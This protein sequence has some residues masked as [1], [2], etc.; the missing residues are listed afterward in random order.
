[1]RRCVLMWPFTVNAIVLLPDHLHAMW[2]LPP[3]DTAY[4]A[5]WGWIKKEFSREWLT[6]G[7]RELPVSHAS[8]QEGRRGVWQPRY[9]EHT[10][11]DEDDFEHH[12]DYIHFNPVKHGYVTHPAAWRW[13]SFHRWANAGVYSHRWGDPGFGF[14]PTFENLNDRVGEPE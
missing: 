5:R 3:G 4:P 6:L 14:Q 12:F 1:M 13:S 8:A 9:W 2:T 10:L 11:E 7:G